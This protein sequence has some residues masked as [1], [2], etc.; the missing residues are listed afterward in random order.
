[1]RVCRY[2]RVQ[3]DRVLYSNSRL[4]RSP[5]QTRICISIF[6]SLSWVAYGSPRQLAQQPNAPFD[7]T[8]GRG[9]VKSKRGQYYDALHV[10]HCVVVLWLLEAACNPGPVAASTQPHI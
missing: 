7:H 9:W 5:L 3:Y 2:E 10:K 1:M 6:R 8:T 4:A